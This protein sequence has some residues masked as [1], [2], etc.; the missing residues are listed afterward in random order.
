MAKTSLR[1]AQTSRVR[2]VS[3]EIN[4]QAKNLPAPFSTPPLRK[5]RSPFLRQPLTSIKPSSLQRTPLTTPIT[6][7]RRLLCTAGDRPRCHDHHA[8]ISPLENG[9]LENGR[10]RGFGS[11]A[12]FPVGRLGEQ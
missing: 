7:R 9:G 6:Y 12:E 1:K 10:V 8:T 2:Q 5:Q 3:G 11:V 4:D